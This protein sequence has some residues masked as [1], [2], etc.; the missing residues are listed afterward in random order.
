MQKP[1][2]LY[3]ISKKLRSSQTPWEAKLWARLR[4][5]RFY[6]LKFKRQVPMGSYVVDFCCQ[7]KKLILE[8]DGGHHNDQKYFKGDISRQKYLESH[9]YTVLRFWNN[10]VDSNLDGVL[11]NIRKE[12]IK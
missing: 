2:D 11:E 3:V 4:G 12:F 9:G 10:E 6:C 5:N 1:R 8:L 7:E